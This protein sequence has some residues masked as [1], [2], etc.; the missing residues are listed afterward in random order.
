MKKSKISGERDIN[1]LLK[2]IQPELA[3]EI[4]VFCSVPPE[5][6][7]RLPVEPLCR[8]HEKEGVTLVLEKKQADKLHIS[9]SY[10]CR[11]ITLSVHSG[12]NAVGFLSTVTAVL[13]RQGIS[14]NVVSAFYHDHLFIEPQNTDKALQ[15]LQ[16]FS[17]E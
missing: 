14:I 10:E 1:V 7:D 15:C 17:T 12:L 5:E 3:N 11:M 6:A 2:S 9:Y 16:A 8:F 13:A 4:Y